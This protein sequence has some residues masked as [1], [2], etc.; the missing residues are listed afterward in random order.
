MIYILILIVLMGFCIFY[1]LKKKKHTG[2]EFRKYTVY[3]NIFSIA[4]AI[5]FIIEDLQANNRFIGLNIL[6]ACL[7][8]VSS[9][10]E[11]RKL[12]DTNY[13]SFDD[14]NVKK[15]AL[16]LIVFNLLLP[17]FII[18]SIAFR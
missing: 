14:T 17:F 12:N 6:L 5:M 1:S 7:I 11:I 10:F 4:L 18:I 9:L 16:N 8:I 3:E 2:Y 13:V 15:S